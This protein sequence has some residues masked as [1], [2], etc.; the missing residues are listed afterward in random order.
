MV[1]FL[2]LSSSASEEKSCRQLH[3]LQR[4]CLPQYRGITGMKKRVINSFLLIGYTFRFLQF[5]QKK[6]FSPQIAGFMFMS[7]SVGKT[8]GSCTWQL[9]SKSCFPIKIKK[10][11][12]SRRS[13]VGCLN[14]YFQKQK[15]VLI[16]SVKVFT[17]MH[18]LSPLMF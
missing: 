1:S 3:V 14:F 6:A 7:L 17:P 11:I 15:T 5:G 9:L 12:A 8:F 16:S 18:P 10:D 13:I 4:N 2:T